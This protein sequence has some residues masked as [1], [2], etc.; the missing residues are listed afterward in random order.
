MR[1][2][3]RGFSSRAF[4]RARSLGVF[5]RRYRKVK[6]R[7]FRPK[8]ISG[9]PRVI[10]YGYRERVDDGMYHVGYDAYIAF[11]GYANGKCL[12]ERHMRVYKKSM[13]IGH[14]P[15]VWV[16]LALPSV[17]REAVDTIAAAANSSTSS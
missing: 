11:R 2:M 8:D 14:R 3:P 10:V 7:D 9:E 6:Q 17:F 16:L 1:V 13:T 12:Y 4:T 15:V 5:V